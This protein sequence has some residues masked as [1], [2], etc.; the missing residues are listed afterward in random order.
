M[1]RWMPV[2]VSLYLILILNLIVTVVI[3]SQSPLLSTTL[4]SFSKYADFFIT[5]ATYAVCTPLL[6]VCIVCVS[7]FTLEQELCLTQHSLY[8]QLLD[9]WMRFLIQIVS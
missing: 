6:A 2:N 5:M 7:P 8:W 4:L 3:G 1:F 9:S